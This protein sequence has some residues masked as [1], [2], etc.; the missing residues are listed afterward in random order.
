MGRRKGQDQ[1]LL[2][3]LR[4]TMDIITSKGFLLGC[5][6]MESTGLDHDFKDIGYAIVIEEAI[7]KG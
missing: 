3:K 6:G 2:P 7:S 5:F 4:M 1:G